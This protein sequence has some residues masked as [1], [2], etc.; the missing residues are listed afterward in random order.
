MTTGGYR[1][2]LT[3]VREAELAAGSPPD[4]APDDPLEV[5]GELVT[6]PGAGRAPGI[7]V[8]VAGVCGGAGASIVTAVIAF[9]AGVGAVVVDATTTGDDLPGRLVTDPVPAWQ[10]W[11]SGGG[12]EEALSTTGEGVLVAA[13]DI[14]IPDYQSP[15]AAATTRMRNLGLRPVVNIGTSLGSAWATPVVSDVAGGAADLVLVVPDRPDGANRARPM[16]TRVAALGE[17]VLARTAVVV[18]T[19]VPGLPATVTDALERGLHGRVAGVTRLPYDRH[20]AAGTHIAW[21]ECAATTREAGA[22]LS[23][24]LTGRHR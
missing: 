13:R 18:T 1:T 7:P 14:T 6:F 16:L 9:T 20:L 19:Q 15:I 12:D 24:S 4:T 23:R 5:A 10:H 22:A 17:N 3:P 2:W 11:L 21:S 8:V